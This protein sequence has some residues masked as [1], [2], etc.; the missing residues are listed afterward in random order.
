MCIGLV[1]IVLDSEPG[2]NLGACT[3]VTSEGKMFT[4]SSFRF[5]Q[6]GHWQNSES[7]LH[8]YK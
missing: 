8:G 3:G 4:H 7:G 2:S 6:S 5:T 1:V